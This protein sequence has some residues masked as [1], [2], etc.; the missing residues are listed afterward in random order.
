MTCTAPAPHAVL[1]APHAVSG[2]ACPVP[3]TPCAVQTPHRHRLVRLRCGAAPCGGLRNETCAKDAPSHLRFATARQ[4]GSRSYP[5]TAPR[6]EILVATM[7]AAGRPHRA[8]A[9][10]MSTA[11]ERTRRY[12]ERA[13]T[14]CR[15]VSWLPEMTVKSVGERSATTIHISIFKTERSVIW[16][17]WKK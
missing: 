17:K 9:I 11:A 16:R 15:V 6:T 1:P 7:R 12:Q 14:G 5:R 3:H 13:C 4:A 10:I 2:G 8:V